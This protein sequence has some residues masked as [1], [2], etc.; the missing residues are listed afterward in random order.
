MATQLSVS[1]R[2]Q[3]R[4]PRSAVFALLADTT[5]WER[6]TPFASVVIETSGTA[7]GVGEVKRTRYRGTSG[8]DRT[9]SLTP[10]SQLTYEYVAGLFAPYIRDYL[11]VVDLEESDGVTTIHWHATFRPRFPGSGW[12]PRR[13]IEQF[14]KRC[15]DGLAGYAESSTSN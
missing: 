3:S 14:L 15:T 8:R 10:D 7:N 9:L 11:A 4:A 2:A 5:T 13:M 6:W 1:A 12:L